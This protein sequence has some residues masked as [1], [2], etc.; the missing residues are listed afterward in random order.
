MAETLNTLVLNVYDQL[1]IDIAPTRDGEADILLIK[2]NNAYKEIQRSRRYPSDYTDEMISAD[3]E[4][5]FT[6]IYN[7]AMY[8]YNMRGAEGQSIINENGEY[9]S[10][11]KRV[12]LL[13]GVL[14]ICVMA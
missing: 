6:E 1:M 2:T 11:V 10:F 7:L 5:Y 12:E 14:P 9:R 13:K 8:D 3:M 4:R